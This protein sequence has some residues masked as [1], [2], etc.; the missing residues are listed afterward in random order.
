M[1]ADIAPKTPTIL[2]GSSKA[3]ANPSCTAF[4][5]ILLGN[6]I[7]CLVTVENVGSKTHP[8]GGA[9]Y[10]HRRNFV[11]KVA[12]PARRVMV[13][14]VV[15]FMQLGALGCFDDVSDCGCAAF[16]ALEGMVGAMPLVCGPCTGKS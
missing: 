14:R 1:A 3:S 12:A 11:C 10:S 7:T 9:V 16:A 5:C 8:V 15:F 2:A 4:M 13:R 6:L